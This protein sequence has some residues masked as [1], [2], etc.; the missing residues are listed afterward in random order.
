MRMD[1]WIG[2]NEAGVKYLE[3]FELE[4]DVVTTVFWHD[5]ADPQAK[6]QETRKMGCRGIPPWQ[7]KV[8]R[9]VEGA[10]WEDVGQLQEYTAENEDGGL[11]AY[12]REDIQA[13][14]WSAGPC[15]FIA[16]RDK[17]GVW[18]PET[19]WSEEEINAA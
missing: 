10:F 4:Y 17:N 12:A 15:Y 3:R 18:I 16:L 14:P 1:Q 9:N 5:P 8:I 2:L 19:L 7:R 6:A 11:V 13:V